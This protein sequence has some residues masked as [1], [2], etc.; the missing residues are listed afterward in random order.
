MD[1]DTA[2][3]LVATACAY[4]W[5]V[6]FGILEQRREVKAREQERIEQLR[7]SERLSK[8]FGKK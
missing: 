2:I 1:V 3:L 8:L 4:G 5:F 6:S 7:R